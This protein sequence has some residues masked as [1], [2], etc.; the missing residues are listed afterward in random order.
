MR[1]N[2]ENND[3]KGVTMPKKNKISKIILRKLIGMGIVVLLS[4]LIPGEIVSAKEKKGL[5]IGENFAFLTFGDWSYR[6]TNI[7]RKNYDYTGGWS[8]ARLV[9]RSKVVPLGIYVSGVIANSNC[10]KTWENNYVVG[11]GVERY[12]FEDEESVS[13]LPGNIRFYFEY[14]R[15]GYTKEKGVNWFPSYDLRVGFDIY[16]DYGIG[17]NKLNR[18]SWAEIWGNLGWQKT[19]FYIENYNSIVV[20]LNVKAGFRLPKNTPFSLMP[21]GVADVSWVG[22]HDFYWQNRG[23]IGIG[24]RIMPFAKAKSELLNRLKIFT[25]YFFTVEYFKDKPAGYIPGYDFRVGVIYSIGFWK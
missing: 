15:I 9:W 11:V 4:M 19:N 22:R 10:D 2:I 23:L 1:F 16:K 12:I 24:L 3:I 21:Y 6:Q 18:L 8:Y 13:G 20:G 7:Y 5:D 17:R 25:E 14:L